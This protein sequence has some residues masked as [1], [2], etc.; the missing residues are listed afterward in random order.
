M[1]G[2][3]EAEVTGFALAEE[4]GVAEDAQVV[5]DSRPADIHQVCRDVGGGGLTPPDAGEAGGPV[6]AGAARVG[7]HTRP[8]NTHRVCRDAAGGELPPPDGAQEGAPAT[9][10][11]T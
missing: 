11:H 2:L 4:A 9:S 3:V 6:V 10:R 5:G 1:V 7:G 8:A